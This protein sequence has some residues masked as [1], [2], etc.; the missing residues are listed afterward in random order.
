MRTSSEHTDIGMI[1]PNTVSASPWRWLE[2]VFL[3]VTSIILWATA[4]A[5]LV[6]VFGATATSRLFVTADP[7]F[8]FSNRNLM[9][10]SGVLELG[11]VM[12]FL[13]PI[14]VKV[15]CAIAAYLGVVFLAYRLALY[16]VGF[17]G[18]CACLGDFGKA[19]FVNP[20]LQSGVLTA[21]GLWMVIVGTG[22]IV[23]RR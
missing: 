20:S 9:L 1:H 14:P 2:L 21:V 22:L 8:G 16:M 4:V 17:K 12:A 19:M 6:S 3:W 15:K 11:V 10:A 7:V 18:W 5:K 23:A 13:A